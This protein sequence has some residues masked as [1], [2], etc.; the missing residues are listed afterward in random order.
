MMKR[1]KILITGGAGFIGTHIAQRLCEKNRIVIFDNLRRDSLRSLPAL[2]N[3]PNVTFIKG[4]IL[5]KA[6][7][8]R[9]VKGCDFILHLAAIAGVSSYYKEPV[10]TLQVNLLGTANL[11]EACKDLH[12]K[13]F[14]Y[15]ST[16]EVYG[17]SALDVTEQSLYNVGPITDRRWCYAISKIA[18]ENFV[19]RYGEKFGFK[20]FVI[21]PFNIYGP[22]QTGEGAIS[23]FMRSAMYKKPMVINGDGSPV[24]A[25]C[26][27]SDC[28][29]AVESLL[30]N[31]TVESGAFN[32]GNPKE[33]CSTLKLAKTVCDVVDKKTPLVFKKMNR[34]EV[35]IR[36]PDIKKAK[37]LLGFKP[38]IS[39]R[40]G[41]ERTYHYFKYTE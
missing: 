6:K 19:I 25:W 23:N 2:K 31:N 5:D 33:A 40:E 38:K 29:D 39:L 32:I 35:R 18:G 9:A 15:F 20:A 11:L 12:I 36:I 10:R 27:V 16:S 22:R 3:H 30:E 34:A 26:Y 17:P 37:R 24:R 41:I 8:A 4:D 21:R 28:V 14:I 7:V 1:S 13:K